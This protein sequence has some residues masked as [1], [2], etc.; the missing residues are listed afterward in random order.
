MNRVI[1]IAGPT[2]SGKTALAVELAK[3]YEGEVVSADS[4]QIY[5]SMNIGTAK[6]TVQEQKGIPH[7]LLDIVS[8]LEEFH[9]VKYQEAAK[10]C[11]SEILERKKLP[12]VCGGTGQYINALLYNI[13]YS[14][15]SADETFRKQLAEEARQFGNIHLWERLKEI[16]PAAAENLHPNNVK[17][18]IRALEVYVLTGKRFSDCIEES[19]RQPSPFTFTGLYLDAERTWLYERINLRVDEMM[20]QGLLE[21]TISLYQKGYL[22]GGTSSMG[23]CYKELLPYVE[24]R[25]QGRAD[26]LLLEQCI[27]RLKQATRNYAK[28]QMTWFKRVPELYPIPV[29]REVPFSAVLEKA[30]FQIESS[31]L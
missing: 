30:S 23:I 22:K 27:Q 25:L 1:I 20:E 6:P 13:L 4:M 8:P 17:R 14:E 31:I 9:V 11:I 16:D 26:T 7:H 19:L 29:A 2:A 10:R 12:I 15:T 5:Q 24:Q 3:K 28:R 21:E 18:V